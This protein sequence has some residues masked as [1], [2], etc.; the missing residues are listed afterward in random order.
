MDA[1]DFEM[2]AELQTQIDQARRNGMALDETEPRAVK[3]WYEVTSQRVFIELKN[4]VVVGFP[5]QLLQ[6]LES[7]TPEQ[8]AEVEISPAGYGL[9]WESLDADLA[10][11]QLVAGIFGTKTWMKEL[12]R[13][14]GRATSEAK[15]QASRKNGKLGGRPRKSKTSVK[16]VS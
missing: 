6:G 12:G 9:H 8:L 15:T 4:G 1:I 3:A 5:S 2:D 14:G 16:S 10:V 13:C 11:P 7:A